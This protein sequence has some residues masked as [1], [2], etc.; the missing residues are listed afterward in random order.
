[1]FYNSAQIPNWIQSN[2]FLIPTF[3]AETPTFPL[4]VLIGLNEAKIIAGYKPERIAP[5]I[6]TIKSTN[7]KLI[8]Q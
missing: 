8:F 7:T 3:P 6:K 4:R 1:M 5:E 2:I